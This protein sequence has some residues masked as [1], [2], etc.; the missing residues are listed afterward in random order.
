MC[1][2]SGGEVSFL[3]RSKEGGDGVQRR[4]EDGSCGFKNDCLV[5]SN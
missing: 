5:N 2:Q 3:S 1:V 4:G